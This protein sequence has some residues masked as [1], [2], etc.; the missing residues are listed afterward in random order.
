MLETG[1]IEEDLTKLQIEAAYWIGKR[2]DALDLDI[3]RSARLEFFHCDVFKEFSYYW[4]GEN[5]VVGTMDDLVVDG[6]CNDST[7]LLSKVHVKGQ[8]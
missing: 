1:D 3:S 7:R 6:M 8:Q 5:Y 4:L 2:S